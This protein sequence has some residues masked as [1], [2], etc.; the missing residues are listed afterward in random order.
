MVLTIDIGN[1]RTKVAIFDNNKFV[2]Y[3]VFEPIKKENIINLLNQY[4]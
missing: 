4:G 1:T 3:A 2:E